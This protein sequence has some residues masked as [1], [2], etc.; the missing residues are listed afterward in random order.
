MIDCQTR[1]SASAIISGSLALSIVLLGDGGPFTS[2][3]IFPGLLVL[4]NGWAV[5]YNLLTFA[6]GRSGEAFTVN[7]M[8]D[9]GEPDRP[10]S[11]RLTTAVMAVFWITGTTLLATATG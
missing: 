8:N 1:A 6:I 5:I 10:M 2:D 9:G 3:W 7:H 4:F 11:P